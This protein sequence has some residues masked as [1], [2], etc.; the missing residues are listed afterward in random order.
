[1]SGPLRAGLFLE[2]RVKAAKSKTMC[3]ALLLA[4]FGAAQ[5]NLH[6]LQEV[7]SP[8]AFGYINMAIAVVVAALRTVTTTSLSDK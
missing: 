4:V 3:F 2:C 5:V 1:M 7:I 8:A 6:Q